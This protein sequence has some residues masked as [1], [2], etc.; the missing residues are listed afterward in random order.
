MINKLISKSQVRI[1]EWEGWKSQDYAEGYCDAINA[2][3]DLEPIPTL[4][5]DE[6]EKMQKE[7][8]DLQNQPLFESV[9]NRSLID[10][11]IEIINK[12]MTERSKEDGE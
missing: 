9:S 12:Y 7:I 2:V 1:L 8:K 5:A 4:G 11:I 3:L 10:V 6:L